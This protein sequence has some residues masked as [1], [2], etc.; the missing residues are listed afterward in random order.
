MRILDYNEEVVWEDPIVVLVEEVLDLDDGGESATY[1]VYMGGLR[2]VTA[3]NKYA[4]EQAVRDIIKGF[5]DL[6]DDDE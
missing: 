2:V 1:T 5:E 6:D 4:A 3:T